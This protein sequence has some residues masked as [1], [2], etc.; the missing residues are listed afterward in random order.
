MR[1]AETN[2]V[3]YFDFPTYLCMWGV[4]K[5]WG[6]YYFLR[7]KRQDMTEGNAENLDLEHLQW[8]LEFRRTQR[9]RIMKLL[10]EMR[11]SKEVVVFHTRADVK[12]YLKF[13]SD[14][15]SQTNNSS[16]PN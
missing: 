2:T 1:V 12:S 14:K 9:P 13:A 5:R 3:V 16:E 10:N 7:R 15:C 6:Q 4:L 8:I 11:H